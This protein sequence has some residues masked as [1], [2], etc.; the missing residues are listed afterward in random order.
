MPVA[1]RSFDLPLD[2]LAQALGAAAGDLCFATP[3]AGCQCRACRYAA[4]AGLG[5]S[6]NKIDKPF[7][8]VLAITLLRAK[9]PRHDDDHAVGGHT[10]PGEQAQ[11]GARCLVEAR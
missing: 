3:F 11:S 2:R 5:R 1:D 10:A 6:T 8:S 9:T 7:V 4:F